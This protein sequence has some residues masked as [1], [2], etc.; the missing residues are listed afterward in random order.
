MAE[1]LSD[2][3]LSELET[4]CTQMLAVNERLRRTGPARSPHI[5]P[6]VVALWIDEL[7]ARDVPA[8]L[9]E[10]R[11]LRADNAYLQ[12]IQA[13]GGGDEALRA[14]LRKIAR[15]SWKTWFADE[16]ATQMVREAQLALGE[17]EEAPSPGPLG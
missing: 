7:C 6:A 17:S 12:S 16:A 5:S 3:A 13:A 15:M 9:A 11:R 2:D 4:R 10:V 8:L 14:A 1:P